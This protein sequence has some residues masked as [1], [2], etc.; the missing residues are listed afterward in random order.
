MTHGPLSGIRVIDVATLF[1]GPLIATMLGDF[2]ADVIKVEHPKGDPLRTHGF[3]KDGIGL[4][5][6]VASR[7]KR[8]VSLNLS[9]PEGAELLKKMAADVDVVIE[10][11]RPGTM[12]RWGIG[13]ETLH[14]LNPKLVMVRVTGFGQE[15]P[16][17]DR[18][19]FGTLAEA[20]SGFANLM[21]DPA[22][23]PYLPPFGLADGVC[24][25]VGTW[26]AT[27]ALY[28]RD[29]AGG[30]GQ[31]IDLALYEPL[32]T[33]LGAQPTYYDQ[34]GI[35]QTRTGNRT[36]NNAPR[37]LYRTSDGKWVAI[38]TSSDNIAERVMTL[39]GHPEV[40]AE[41][42]F[43]SARGRAEHADLLDNMVAPWIEGRGTKEVMDAFSQAGAA[44]ALVYDAADILPDPHFLARESITTVDDPDLGR[45]R[46]Q[47]VLAKFSATAGVIRWAGKSLGADNEDIYGQELGLS[48]AELVRLKQDGVI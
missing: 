17:S 20:M 3:V 37:N 15:G 24:A 26:A 9:R 4:W 14:A 8:C 28:H 35:I 27:M 7:N 45:I 1:A 25:M 31:M 13:W 46:M 36:P 21:G 2:G 32:M 40:I 10:N 33:I 34:M 43:H 44:A 39:V 19:G 6:K 42:W 5:W 12:E 30:E 29:T 47:N 16:Y 41:P 22:G 18:A 38:S 11:F 48:S 23:P